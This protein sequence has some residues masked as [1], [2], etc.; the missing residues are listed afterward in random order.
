MGLHMNISSSCVGEFGEVGRAVPE[1]LVMSG[2]V[3][4][5]TLNTAHEQQ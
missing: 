2:A 5:F 3:K 4:I 1:A